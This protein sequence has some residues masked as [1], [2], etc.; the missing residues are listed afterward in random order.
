[1]IIRNTPQ[2][3]HTP[4]RAFHTTDVKIFFCLET[5]LYLHSIITK[6]EEYE[7]IGVHETVQR[8]RELQSILQVIQRA[9]RYRL[10]EVRLRSSLLEEEQKRVG[11]Q[12]LRS[13]NNFDFWYDY[14]RHEVAD[15]LLVHR[16][17]SSDCYK[18][19]VLCR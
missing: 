6:T 8:R 15:A 10:P 4:N 1:M 2:V 14:A 12:E 18:E 16:Y 5:F 11:V 9:E 7:Y 13:Q 19:N 17:S 3:F